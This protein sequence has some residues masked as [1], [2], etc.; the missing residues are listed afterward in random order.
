VAV[1][2]F[3]SIFI[4]CA[5]VFLLAGCTS[6]YS[7]LAPEIEDRYGE[8]VLSKKKGLSR[9]RVLAKVETPSV[10]GQGARVG[11]INELNVID[12]AVEFKRE[13]GF[14]LYRV[15]LTPRRISAQRWQ[16]LSHEMSVYIRTKGSKESFTLPTELPKERPY[17]SLT[18]PW[19]Y[20]GP[21]LKLN[22]ESNK[23]F[24]FSINRQ[25][26]QLLENQD[27]G[28]T[29]FLIRFETPSEKRYQ[30]G[31]A[32]N[33]TLQ[34][35][36][37]KEEALTRERAAEAERQRLAKLQEEENQ[38]L[39]GA[40]R[41]AYRELTRT[42]STESLSRGR[43]K[44]CGK[45]EFPRLPNPRYASAN[46]INKAG[47]KSKETFKRHIE[48]VTGFLRGLDTQ[49]WGPHLNS[50]DEMEASLWPQTYLA[51][52]QR[53]DAL[54]LSES[55]EAEKEHLQS[56]HKT[57][58]DRVSAME[59]NW[60]DYEHYEKVRREKAREKK[61]QAEVKRCIYTLAS[62]GALTNYS[63]GYCRA[64]AEKGISGYQAGL[65]GSAGARPPPPKD[66][67]LYQRNKL[68]TFDLQGMIDN[69]QAVADGASAVLLWDSSGAVRTSR[70]PEVS[71]SYGNT[72]GRKTALDSAGTSNKQ[73]EGLDLETS[74]N[75]G[76]VH[77]SNS[78]QTG[79]TSTAPSQAKDSWPDRFLVTY[80][81]EEGMTGGA[82]QLFSHKKVNLDLVGDTVI[83][84]R[85]KPFI[86]SNRQC[87]EEQKI[88]ASLHFVVTAWWNN[89]G[90]QEVRKVQRIAD[91]DP[92]LAIS[93]AD[94][95]NN[96][97]QSVI[98][99]VGQL[100]KTRKV[101]WQ[102]TDKFR[103]SLAGSDCKTLVW[104]GDFE[105]KLPLR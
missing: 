24:S 81:E 75:E 32:L 40:V 14:P 77:A 45:L 86:A 69:A 96:D 52:S 56:L 11:N 23:S 73:R 25:L 71:L 91:R 34:K 61:I 83:A 55:L 98:N 72:D 28:F 80:V 79:A 104:N 3:Y 68:P 6:F 4:L 19:T 37:E 74:A 5:G 58:R 30:I 100:Y 41:E 64:Q 29:S 90:R 105:S 2:R 102:N 50:M 17:G 62:K 88:T 103:R 20:C 48:C 66:V 65:T 26:S 49:K 42:L 13:Y 59:K 76:I 10:Y 46:D 21:C 82:I 43:F 95:S 47:V 94:E 54:S 22:P 12:A 8:S 16:A 36:K 39:Y 15:H 51:D 92:L 9:V 67:L 53:G 18:T 27:V 35:G 57:Y 33:V 101:H 31:D 97:F 78:T 38:R 63:Q 70:A 60:K 99:G 44:A 85:I 93:P 1:S 7:N 84:V 89:P 87:N